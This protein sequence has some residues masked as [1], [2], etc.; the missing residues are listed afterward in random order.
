MHSL[1][2]EIGPIKIFS[3]GLCMALGFLAAWQV[4]L[5]LCKRSGQNAEQV[6][7]V[8]TGLMLTGV[9]GARVAYVIEHWKLEFASHPI[10]VFRFDQGGL[11]FYGGFIS[12]AIFVAVYIR[13]KKI[14]LFA[15][16]DVLLTAMPLGHAFGRFGCF[17][18]GC[19][20]GKVT[21]SHLGVCFPKHSPAWYEQVYA[22]PPLL[23]ELALKSLP[24]IPTQL[25]EC[26][27]NLILFA[28]LFK[29][30]PKNWKKRGFITGLYLI[31]YAVMR[32]LIEFLRGDPRAAVGP[33]SISQAIG[34]LLVAVGLYAISYSRNQGSALNSEL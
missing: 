10:S 17:M 9:I 7:S 15:L 6:T 24:V 25:I 1:L 30:Y 34:L 19:C 22:T 14:N 5:W 33:L 11:M 29:L 28:V 32:F 27:A 21:D 31:S 4:A 18:H 2:L 16:S 13:V 23:D 3:Y 8:L 20:Y 26:A 12:A